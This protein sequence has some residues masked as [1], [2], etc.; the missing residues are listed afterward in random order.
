MAATIATPMTCTTAAASEVLDL[1]DYCHY[2][3]PMN[4]LPTRS[5]DLG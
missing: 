5:G 2:M 4:A 3:T 1:L